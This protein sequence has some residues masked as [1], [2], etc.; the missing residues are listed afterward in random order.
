MEKTILF[1][2]CVSNTFVENVFAI[3]ARDYLQ[4]FYSIPLVYVSIFMTV[5]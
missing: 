2:M 3:D 4:A 5:P 1:P